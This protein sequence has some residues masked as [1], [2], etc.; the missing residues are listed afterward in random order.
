MNPGKIK[1]RRSCP[2]S[3]KSFGSNRVNNWIAQSID[4]HFD[5]PIVPRRL[6]TKIISDINNAVIKK[7]DLT[8]VAINNDN[9]IQIIM[10]KRYLFASIILDVTPDLTDADTLA[11]FDEIKY[12]DP[13]IIN[14]QPSTDLNNIGK[15]CQ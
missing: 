3:A 14:M 5:Q 6:L 10:Y 2:P 11:A 8:T 9:I 4:H 7:I 12:G 15:P 13:D 1:Y